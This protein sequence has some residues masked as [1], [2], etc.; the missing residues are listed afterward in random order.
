MKKTGILLVSFLLATNLLAQPN[1]AVRNYSVAYGKKANF[2]N[3][4][5]GRLF[6]KGQYNASTLNAANALRLA[7][8]KGQISEAQRRL[9]DSYNRAVQENLM[10]IESLQAGSATF[11]NDQTVTDRAAIVSIYKIM[12][13]YNGILSTLPKS[14][15]DPVKRKDPKLK[16]DIVDYKSELK[17]ATTNL[18]EGKKE[19]AAWHYQQGR[20]LGR[21]SDLKTNKQAARHFRWAMIYVP[22]YEDSQSRYEKA[23]L[24]G[25]TRLGVVNFTTASQVSQYGDLGSITSD[26]FIARMPGNYEFFELVSRDQ[27]DLIISEQELNIS[28][29]MDENSTTEVG[30]LKGVNVLLVGK[31]SS[32][33]QD[34]QQGGGTETYLEEKEVEDGEEKYVDSDGKEKTRAI[35]KTVSAKVKF[36]HKSASGNVIGSFKLLDVKTGSITRAGSLVGNYSWE[37]RWATYTGDK[38]ALKSST[39]SLVNNGPGNFPARNQ[40]V[41]N[42]NE[43]LV[44]NLVNKVRQYANEVG[45][46]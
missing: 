41:M 30:Q 38:R 18:E 43:E 14:S 12:M 2:Y 44:Q 11:V 42:A 24:L 26:Q 19:A 40:M 39:R 32:A 35:Y 16:L 23:R 20:D 34:R 15:F 1:F 31:L 36:Y 33:S 3:N 5:A 4:E 45:K 28:G 10:R 27:L 25:T 29:L 13:D 6:K 37:H 7:T 21:S 46:Y 22:S 8:K 17:Q 9:F